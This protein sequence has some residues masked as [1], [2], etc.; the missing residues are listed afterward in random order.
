ML[1][2]KILLLLVA[3]SIILS[4]I[5]LPS[6]VYA[7]TETRALDGEGTETG[8]TYVGGALDY[9]NLNSDDGDTSYLN[10]STSIYHDWSYQ[11]FNTSPSIN[12]VSIS[13]KGK[14][15]LNPSTGYIR[16]YV[17]ISGTKYYG[18][19]TVI[20]NYSWATVTYTWST[21]PATGTA[22]TQTTVNSNTFGAYITPSQ[23]SPDVH[24]TYVYLTVNYNPVE[25]PVLDTS[26]PTDLVDTSATL[27]G[28]VTHDGYLDIDERGFVWDTSTHADPGNVAP[29]A[30]G[31]ANNWTEVGTFGEEIFSRATG[32]VL[33]TGT[34]YYYRACAE[35]TQGWAYGDEV[36]FTTQGVPSIT[37]QAAT[38]INATA[39]RV[40]AL[41][42]N[43][44]G[45]DCDVRF[46][47]G[48]TSHS[49][50]CTGASGACGSGTCNGTI[51]D[52]CTAWV[53]N[54]YET[55][56]MPYTNLTGLTVGTTYYFCAQVRND[57][58]CSC[59]GELSF[60]TETG[61]YTPTGLQ[62]IPTSSTVS[63]W[64]VKGDGA[65]NTLIRRKT[66]SYP[67]DTTDGTLVYFDNKNSVVDNTLTRG[68][69]YYYRAWG[70]SGGTYSTNNATLMI[71]TLAAIDTTDDLAT[72]PTESSWFQA[73]DY[74]KA[75]NIPFYDL[76]NWGFDTYSLPASTGWFL[77]AMLFVAGTG[78][79][80][81]MVTENHNL[82]ISMV[83]SMITMGIL[84]NM[85]LIMGW[86]LLA[87]AVP[88]AVGIFVGER[89]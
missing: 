60:T 54:T 47:Y 59:G 58:G 39:A 29:A 22:W 88:A 41:I 6:P 82:L 16:P 70:E 67:A 55:G 71:T 37:T 53:E 18:P 68:T 69:T 64:W 23:G 7:A 65:T 1:M 30:S 36:T 33:T 51:Y 26:A 80:T 66:G 42:N 75:S 38:Y 40:N 28:E 19:S 15:T 62:G 3:L 43:D 24:V 34:T 25:L 61:I 46:C 63:L 86:Y 11:T 2:R 73:P 17:L 57:I 45:E 48:T 77:I 85:G 74:T 14:T 21:N 4:S 50:N 10:I 12:S 87:L 5:A 52:N 44:G 78:I 83:A 20:T 27:N 56:S 31:Y 84:V 35:N 81:Y 76:I 79:A 72:P 8:G 9:T 13:V 49:A 32:A 89:R